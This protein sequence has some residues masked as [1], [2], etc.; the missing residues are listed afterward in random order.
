MDSGN[1]S[2]L[3]KGR[4]LPLLLLSLFL[5]LAGCGKSYHPAVPKEL[6]PVREPATPQAAEQ[7]SILR[8][9]GYTIQV[10][11]FTNLDNAVRL[12]ERLTKAGLPA[13]YYVH[14]SGQFKVRF[15]DYPTYS[16]ALAKAKELRAAGLIEEYYLV[17]PE[18]YGLEKMSGGNLALRGKLVRTAEKF[19]GIPYKWGGESD[20]EGFD[21][22]GLT[23]VVYRLNGFNLPRNSEA[24]FQSGVAVNRK[25]LRQGDLLFFAPHGGGRATHVGI[26]AGDDRFI[27]AP[28]QGRK[29]TTS[30]MDSDYY[31]KCY[32]GARRYL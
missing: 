24:Q 13:Y 12:T 26:Y 31:R 28:K 25:E 15:G 11:A 4:V 8:R 5:L 32:L 2:W 19:I 1:K 10:G 14:D 16:E 27:H 7:P 17:N 3:G 18:S 9:L 6:A 30:S 21:C 20:E 22:S 23:M 29:I